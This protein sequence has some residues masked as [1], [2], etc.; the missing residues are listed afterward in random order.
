MEGHPVSRLDMFLS[1]KATCHV[2][3]TGSNRGQPVT[4]QSYYLTPRVSVYI[5]LEG[6]T[7]R[8][9]NSAYPSLVACSTRAYSVE[10]SRQQSDD[11][12]G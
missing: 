10:Q 1:S 7:H 9:Q 11:Y 5:E 2:V 12:P 4:P 8:W 3:T 6:T